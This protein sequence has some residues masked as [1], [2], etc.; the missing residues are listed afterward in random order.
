VFYCVRENNVFYCVWRVWILQ[1][2]LYS[3]Y[4]KTKSRQAFFGTWLVII[5]ICTNSFETASF[6]LVWNPQ[7][8]APIT[9]GTPTDGGAVIRKR[10]APVST[11]HPQWTMEWMENSSACSQI[12]ETEQ[13]THQETRS[14]DEEHTRGTIISFFLEVI[15]RIY[16]FVHIFHYLFNVCKS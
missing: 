14:K 1:N 9:S 13:N 10:K 3:H 7:G 12:Q 2:K 8:S 6:F 15:V 16:L 4:E 11:V 5:Y